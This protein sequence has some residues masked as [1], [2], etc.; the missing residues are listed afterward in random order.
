MAALAE[1]GAVAT[2]DEA[3]DWLAG[4]EPLADDAAPI[5]VTFDDGTADLVDIAL[6]ILERYAIPSTVYVATDFID[7]CVSFPDDGRPLSWSALREMTSTGLVSVGSHT[8]THAL[9]DRVTPQ[10]AQRE[11]ETSI[12]LIED[13]AGYAAAHFAYPKAVAP[14]DPIDALVRTRFRSAALAGTRSNVRGRT[15][16]HRLA[17]TPIQLGDG[18]R[19]FR[20]KIDGGLEREDDLRRVANRLRYARATK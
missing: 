13:R 16:V 7:R 12:G 3:L 2:L 8:H 18:M 15:D 1:R 19:W 11:I 14:S 17:R 9:L 20:R 10:S 6:P 4:T 5:V